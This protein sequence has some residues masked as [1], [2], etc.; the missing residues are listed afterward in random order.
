M[1]IFAAE[2]NRL[3]LMSQDAVTRIGA[4]IGEHAQL[5]EDMSRLWPT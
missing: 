4:Y 3:R 5:L 2:Q 1:L